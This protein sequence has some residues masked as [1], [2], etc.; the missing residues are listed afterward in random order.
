MSER[1]NGVVSFRFD[2]AYASVSADPVY[3]A[4]YIISMIGNEVGPQVSF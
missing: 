3:I 4:S 1:V 2:T